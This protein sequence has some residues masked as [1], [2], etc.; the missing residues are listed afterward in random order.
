MNLDYKF[1]SEYLEHEIARLNKSRRVFVLHKGGYLNDRQRALETPELHRDWMWGRRMKKIQGLLEEA[2]IKL[3]H[4]EPRIDKLI[5]QQAI[6][7][8][9][10]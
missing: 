7:A 10:I 5:E 4:I 6:I 8:T 9:K 3:S 2:D 1:L